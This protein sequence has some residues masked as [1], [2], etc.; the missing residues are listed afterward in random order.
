MEKIKN[1]AKNEFWVGYN[2]FEKLF[3]ASMLLLQI[4]VYMIVPDI[5]IG[6]ISGISGVIS[7]V[8][9]AK[10]KISFY[11]IGFVQ[12]I[13]YLYLA[14]TNAFYGEVI[15][16]V[17]Y[18]VT[19][20]W[21]IFIWKKNMQKNDDGTED[22]KAKK[23]NWWQLIVSVALTLVATFIMGYWLDSIGS[24]QAYLDAATNVMAIFAQLLM[25]WRFR[26]Q[27]IWWVV[28]DV[29]CIVMWFNVGNWSMV[30]MYIA[31]TVNAIYGWYN[32]SKLNKVQ[33]DHPT[34]KGDSG[35]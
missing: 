20:V 17:F 33:S 23:F 31:W 11:F 4:I 1:W 8:L 35:E 19:M 15:E 25:I 7:V 28:I 26:E 18:L 24:N 27:W 9:C 5:I 2:L 21:G 13:S 34:E 10:G 12:T 3:L 32:W 29:I 14:W 22:V 30:A 16:N 6:I